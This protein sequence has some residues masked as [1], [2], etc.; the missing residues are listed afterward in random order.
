V[1]YKTSKFWAAIFLSSRCAFA[2]QSA[3]PKIFLI[4]NNEKY[5]FFE[6]DRYSTKIPTFILLKIIDCLQFHNFIA[7]LK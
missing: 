3:A 7:I 4:L 5:L 6:I 1:C 2:T